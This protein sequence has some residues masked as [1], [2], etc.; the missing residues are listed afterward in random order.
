MG[1]EG[2]EGEG[3][4]AFGEP[5]AGG[6]GDERAVKKCGSR[7]T[8]GAEEEELAE[9]G[10][11]EVGAADDLGDVEIGV[12]DGAGELVAG[13]VVFA[14]DEEVAE[15]AAGD[16]A[17]RAEVEIVEDELFVVG[18]AEAPVGLDAIGEWW[19]RGVG[20]RTEGFGIDRFVVEMRGAGGFG[21]VAARTRAGEDESGGVEAGECGAVEREALALRE[22]GAVP[23]DAE[24]VEI[25]LESGDELGPAAGGV[26]V[27]VAEDERAV[28]GAGALVGD[29]ECARVTEVKVAGG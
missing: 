12:V 7:N 14:P 8:E 4:V 2:A 1:A 29:P 21:D 28:R 5:L 25:F 15:V 24:P 10:F 3:V 20:R 19:E 6:V 9:R 27:V 26:E 16:G 18:D 11:D 23:A 22:E 17:L 13:D